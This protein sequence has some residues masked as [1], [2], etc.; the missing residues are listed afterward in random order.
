MEYD[1]DITN[2]EL[3]KKVKT[4]MA[5][6]EIHSPDITKM[7]RVVDGDKVWYYHKD[8]RGTEKYHKKLREI[9]NRPLVFE[10]PVMYEEGESISKQQWVDEHSLTC[11]DCVFLKLAHKKYYRCYHP[12]NVANPQFNT[13][14][15][16]SDVACNK[17]ELW[18]VENL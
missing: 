14:R 16:K 4:M 1:G 8:P 10:F 3:V 11:S 15:L 17:L 7:H 12:E 13:R 2:E 18:N 5:N 9:R 6:G